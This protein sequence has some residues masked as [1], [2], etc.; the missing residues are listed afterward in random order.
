MRFL[1]PL[2]ILSALFAQESA[3]FRNWLDQGGQT[4]RNAQYAAAIQA[5]QRAIDL[6]P[7]SL[8][9]HLYLATAYMQ[10]YIPGAESKENSEIAARAKEE[11]SKVLGLTPPTR[12]PWLR[13]LPFT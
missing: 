8:M 1:S 3:E 13:W 2:F 7:S 6:N 4:F 10:Q 5:F 12:W 9:A 11:F